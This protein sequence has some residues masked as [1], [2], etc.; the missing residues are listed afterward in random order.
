MTETLQKLYLELANVVPANCLSS[1]EIAALAL[2]GE[3]EREALA[4]LMIRQSIATGH[5]DTFEDL[6]GELERW[7]ED[8]QGAVEALIA[9]S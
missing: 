8:R 9:K 3:A 4:A 6:L 1:R 5:G 7:I 2:V